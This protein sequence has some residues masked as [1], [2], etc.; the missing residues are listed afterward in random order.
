VDDFNHF[1][2]NWNKHEEAGAARKIL[3][4]ISLCRNYLSESEKYR[5]WL[6]KPLMYAI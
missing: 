3:F 6:P 2:D 1:S 5:V 4:A